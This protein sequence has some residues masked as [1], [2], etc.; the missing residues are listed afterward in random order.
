MRESK[1]VADQE[2]QSWKIKH[3]SL[4]HWVTGQRHSDDNRGTILIKLCKCVTRSRTDFRLS[5]VELLCPHGTE[6]CHKLQKLLP[7]NISMTRCKFCT[8]RIVHIQATHHALVV[9][10]AD[11][12]HGKIPAVKRAVHN[13]TKHTPPVSELWRICNLFR[14]NARP[15]FCEVRF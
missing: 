8:M 2:K 3:K 10:N 6:N 13:Y 1:K 7:I 5:S 12:A 9:A 11:R 4:D 14:K 15:M